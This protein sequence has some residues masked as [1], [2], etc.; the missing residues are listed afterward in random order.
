MTIEYYTFLSKMGKAVEE[1][2][3][4]QY[5]HEEDMLQSY[6]EEE[7]RMRRMEDGIYND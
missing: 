5:Q 7:E 6:R 3:W 4:M 2:V 1:F